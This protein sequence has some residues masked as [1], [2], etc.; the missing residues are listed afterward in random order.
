MATAR[1]AEAVRDLV[2]RYPR[3][4]RAVALDVTD[5][6]AAEDAVAATVEAFG[7]VDV[8][9]NNAGYSNISSIENTPLDD[10]RA[11]VETNLWGAVHVTRAALPLMRAQRGGH[12]VQISSVSGRVAPMPGLGPYVT[13]KFALEGFSEAPALEM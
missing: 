7:G 13:A 1:D 6:Q 11:Q 3:T 5:P 4:A 9:V 2:Q 8:V 12:V 10:F